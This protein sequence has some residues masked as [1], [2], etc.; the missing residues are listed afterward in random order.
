MSA[1]SNIVSPY[2]DIQQTTDALNNGSPTSK[3]AYEFC[4]AFGVQV[5]LNTQIHVQ[6]FQVLS[7]SGIPMGQIYC[8]TERNK[9]GNNETI[10]YFQSQH[11]IQKSKGSSRSDRS[12]RDSNSIK[13]LITTLKKQKEIPQVSSMYKS[14]SQGLRFAFSNVSNARQPSVSI[15]GKAIID[16][17]EHVLLD[18]PLSSE[19]NY[20]LK[21]IYESYKSEMKSFQSSASNQDRFNEGAKVIAIC[22]DREKP[23]YLVGEATYDGK[24]GSDGV[25]FQGD[26]KRYDS[27]KN[28]PE[29]AVDVAMISAYMEGLPNNDKR[30]ELFLPRRDTYYSDIDVATG[31]SGDELWVAIPKTAP[32]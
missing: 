12:T 11:I 18:R 16:L 7:M 3:L 13:S 25:T 24:S 5:N 21:K 14:L 23:Y 10:Y 4:T 22:G 15:G 26:L 27:L 17:I 1:I 28:S 19:Q 32:L 2:G 20:E 9:D 31:Y 8:S 29:F 30:N 6:R